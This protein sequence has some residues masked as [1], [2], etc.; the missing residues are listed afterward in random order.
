MSSVCEGGLLAY[1]ETMALI[2]RALCSGVM[3]LKCMCCFVVRKCK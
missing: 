3:Q 1:N 2:G